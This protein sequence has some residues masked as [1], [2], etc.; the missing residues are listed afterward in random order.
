MYYLATLIDNR[1]YHI[2]QLW[3]NRSHEDRSSP[4]PFVLEHKAWQKRPVLR[5]IRQAKVIGHGGYLLDRWIDWQ[6]LDV[7][8]TAVGLMLCAQTTH[9][10]PKEDDPIPALNPISDTV[11]HTLNANQYTL[12]VNQQFT[13]MSLPITLS[14]DVE[15]TTYQSALLLHLVPP[16]YIFDV[17][18]DFGSEASQIVTYQRGSNEPLKRMKMVD[19][20]IHHFY[21]NMAGKDLH[22][23]DRDEELFR[24]AFFIKKEGS[25]FYLTAKP[26][27]HGDQEYVNLL[28]DKAQEY[29]LVDK[30]ILVSNLKLAH[31]GAYLFDVFF[32]SATTNACRAPKKS[33]LATIDKLQQAVVNYFMQMV[34]EEIRQNTPAQDPIYVVVKL[35]VPNVFAQKKVATL[36]VGTVTGLQEIAR[37]N[38]LLNVQGAEVSTLSE[39]DA[40]F[41]GFKSEQDDL[42]SKGEAS[43]FEQGGRYL[44]VDVGK[45]TTDFSILD[46]D[47]VTFKITSLYRSGFI[48]AGNILSYAF[49]DTVFTAI[50]GT[51]ELDRKRAIQA[52]TQRADISDKIRFTDVIEKLKHGYDPTRTYLPLQPPLVDF[53]SIRSQLFEPKETGTLGTI[54]DKL[55][56]VA[57]QQASIGDEWLIINQTVNEIATRIH[58]EVLQSGRF[59]DM[60]TGDV[61]VKKLILT[62][63]GFLF[64][65]LRNAVSKAFDI[66][67]LMT[68]DL[69]KDCLAGPF[70]NHIINYESNLVGFPTI[71]Q[72]F[73][74]PGRQSKQIE[75]GNGVVLNIPIYS[76]MVSWLADQSKEWQ[77]SKDNFAEEHIDHSLYTTQEPIGLGGTLSD[78]EAFL[79]WGENFTNFNRNAKVVSICGLDYK[80]HNIDAATINIFFTGDDF[81]IR[82]ATQADYLQVPPKFFRKTQSVAQ[83]LYPF[84]KISA[85][86]D[87]R[88]MPL[89]DSF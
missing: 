86:D 21:P 44:I 85:P 2:A 81:I 87:V 28:T 32:A 68:N 74:K 48:G 17:V 30:R 35:L 33:F 72:L 24:S 39:S 53:S 83:T 3:A 77:N 31:L 4:V 25:V 65:P 89:T 43:V 71:Y 11:D 8:Q 57:R 73:G 54:A 62:G 63:R 23:Q 40:S 37:S 27:T 76:R 82:D 34:L 18:M 55:E 36:A 26:G 6:T 84:E 16:K 12:W 45:G 52:V 22:Q 69:K 41:L 13:A 29:E 7:Q 58:R 15:G 38:P 80:N 49:T 47:P 64:D 19:Y 1:K 79:N 46:I 88:V 66:P 5:L 56:Q 50:C 78:E 67:T 10:Q 42:A 61:L 60:E 20:L 51:D 14:V 9:E 75:T 59:F 70:S